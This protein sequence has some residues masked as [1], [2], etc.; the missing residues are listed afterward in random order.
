MKEAVCG[1]WE[2]RGQDCR[3]VSSPAEREDKAAPPPPP[4]QATRVPGGS[5][6]GGGLRNIRMGVLG[7]GGR[8]TVWP[9]GGPQSLLLLP[10]SQEAP[11]FPPSQAHHPCPMHLLMAILSSWP[12]PWTSGEARGESDP[13]MKCTLLPTL[14]TQDSLS[15]QGP[16]T[17]RDTQDTPGH[18]QLWKGRQGPRRQGTPSCSSPIQP[19]ASV[20]SQQLLHCVPATAWNSWI[21]FQAC[22]YPPAQRVLGELTSSGALLLS[23]HLKKLF[24]GPIMIA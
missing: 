16:S 23:C 1:A 14:G 20:D 21:E 12:W 13:G 6:G 19:P 10:L 3:T 11:P 9:L 24:M 15:W 8:A 22:I 18:G 17:H 4:S 7:V 2:W 5:A